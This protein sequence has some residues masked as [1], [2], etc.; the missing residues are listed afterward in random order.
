MVKEVPLVWLA[1]SACTGCSVSLLNSAS[2]RINNV[3]IDEIVPE[4]LGGIHKN[5]ELAS[6][7]LKKAFLANFEELS[8]KPLDKLI[9]KRYEKFRKMGALEEKK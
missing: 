5:P 3:L 7:N 1:A 8:Q 9:A 4:P 6:D 2:P